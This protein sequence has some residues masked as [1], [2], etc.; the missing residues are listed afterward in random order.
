MKM[1]YTTLWSLP[2]NHQ[3]HT[4]TTCNWNIICLL[5]LERMHRPTNETR[6]MYFI[7]TITLEIVSQQREDQDGYG[8]KKQRREE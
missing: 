4:V 2:I 6:Y 8:K 3:N 5:E 7:N 1:E